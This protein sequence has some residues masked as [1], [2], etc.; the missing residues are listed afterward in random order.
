[1]QKI[2]KLVQRGKKDFF[3]AEN[4]IEIDQFILASG[5][6]TNTLYFFIRTVD[7]PKNSLNDIKKYRIYSL[8]SNDI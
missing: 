6:T 7:M 3:E 8:F 1:M 4:R 5:K 2:D